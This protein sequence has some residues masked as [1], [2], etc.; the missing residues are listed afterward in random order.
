MP[1]CLIAGTWYGILD[2]L[3]ERNLILL[4]F[5]ISTLSFWVEHKGAWYVAMLILVYLFFPWYYDWA[6]KNRT[7]RVLGSLGVCMGIAW[8]LSVGN[9]RLYAHLGQVIVSLIVYIIGY[10]Y[11]GRDSKNNRNEIILGIVCVTLFLIKTISPVKN[12]AF[13]SGLTWG[14]LGIPFSFIAGV[15][16]G[17]IKCSTVDKILEFTGKHSLEMYLCNIFII[18]AMGEF[19]IIESMK[20]NG[21]D[22]GFFCYSIVIAL[23]V[24]F[25]YFYGKLS[26]EI[27]KRIEC[28]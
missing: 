12:N 14:M 4:L 15:L 16:L 24:L 22:S 28:K 18:Q 21:D 9:P 1:Y 2:L 20:A 6:E 25:S 5:D 19:G 23:G 11:A 8:I 27:A 3:I 13:I 26:T 10:F 7:V 17:L